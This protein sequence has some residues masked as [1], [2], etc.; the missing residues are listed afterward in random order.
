M[1]QLSHSCLIGWVH[2][3]WIL[4]LT[5]CETQPP[6]APLAVRAPTVPS[7][8]LTRHA[9]LQPREKL[10]ALHCDGWLSGAPPGFA[11]EETGLMVIDLWAD[12]CPVVRE[13]APALRQT[14]EKYAQ[15]GVTW[16]SLTNGGPS[17]A[18][19]LASEFQ[20]SWPQGYGL[21]LSTIAELG[22]CNESSG[23]IGYEI[24]PTLYL[25]RGDGTIFWHDGHARLNHGP[26][27][28]TQAALEAEIERHLMA[29]P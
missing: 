12:W 14:F 2:G 24:K 23:M 5:G 1:R 22:V 4:L 13:T 25:V 7:L 15:R 16:F 6:P 20:L 26:P 3:F 28:K 11:E 29:A 10:P 21:S 27:E 8:S 9:I 18:Q 19:A 17:A